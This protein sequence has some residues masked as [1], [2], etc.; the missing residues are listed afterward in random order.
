[1]N[2][3]QKAIL[4]KFG[5]V[6][7]ATPITVTAMIYFKDWVNHT[8]AVRAM[9]H[10]SELVLQYREK[11]GSTPPESYVDDIKEKLMGSAR[12]GDL[13][14]RARWIGMD[15]SS[16]EILA[17]VERSYDSLVIKDGF[18]VLRFDGRVEYMGKKEFN[19]ILARQQSPAEKALQGK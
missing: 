15:C 17:Y 2:K 5:L 11:K 18:I 16:D 7:A 9:E 19:A 6:I 8:E 3:K 10:L 4:N 14:Y 12:I 13:K 1:M